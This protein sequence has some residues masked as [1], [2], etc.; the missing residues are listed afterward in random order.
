[1]SPMEIR[2]IAWQRESMATYPTIRLALRMMMLSAA[3]RR[4]VTLASN[5]VEVPILALAVDVECHIPTGKR[6]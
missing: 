4:T 1:M 3:S 5:H 2:L 6:T